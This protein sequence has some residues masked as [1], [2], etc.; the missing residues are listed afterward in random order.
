MVSG[1]WRSH[2][3]LV[4][5]GG[6]DLLLLVGEERGGDVAVGGWEWLFFARTG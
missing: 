6:V 1:E 2:Q 4:I 3:E 5:A